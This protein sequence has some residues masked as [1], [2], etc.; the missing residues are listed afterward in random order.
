MVKKINQIIRKS[1]SVRYPELHKEAWDKTQN[2]MSRREIL[3]NKIKNNLNEAKDYVDFH[4]LCNEYYIWL[5][6]HTDKL[7]IDNIDVDAMTSQLKIDIEFL[8][9]QMKLHYYLEDFVKSYLKENG[10]NN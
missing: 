3:S 2:W 6:E 5:K 9:K 4:V 8:E 10:R 7:L 1:K